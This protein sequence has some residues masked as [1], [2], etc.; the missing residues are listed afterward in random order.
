MPI[1][2]NNA[3][4]KNANIDSKSSN[5]Q[6]QNDAPGK[7]TSVSQKGGDAVSLTSEAQQLGGLQEKAMNSSGIDQAKVDK[8]KADIESGS[9]KINVEQL[10]NKLAQ[11]ESDLFSN[12]NN[13]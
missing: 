7:P 6:V 11:F 10:A 12:G 3:G 1:N 2:I 5:R 9:Y 13:E 4:L 8:I